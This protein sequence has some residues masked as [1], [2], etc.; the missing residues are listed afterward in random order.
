MNT[1]S[2]IICLFI[3]AVLIAYLIYTINKRKTVNLFITD[4]LFERDLQMAVLK[5]YLRT[6]QKEK[7]KYVRK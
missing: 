1:L 5:A 7:G 6:K 2:V 4:R 3:S